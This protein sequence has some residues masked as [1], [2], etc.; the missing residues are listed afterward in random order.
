MLH[1]EGSLSFGQ[2]GRDL[3]RAMLRDERHNRVLPMLQDR[4]DPCSAP[5]VALVRHMPLL[6]FEREVKRARLDKYLLRRMHKDANSQAAQALVE[7]RQTAGVTLRDKWATLCPSMAPLVLGLV[8]QPTGGQCLVANWVSP[9]QRVVP[10]LVAE[11]ERAENKDVL[12]ALLSERAGKH[13]EQRHVEEQP[14]PEGPRRSARDKPSCLEAGVCLC[15]PGGNLVWRFHS[16]VKGSLKQFERRC[17]M[18]AAVNECRMVV[19][20]TKQAVDEEPE[21]P[22]GTP[23]PPA[24]YDAVFFIGLM[25]WNPHRPTLRECSYSKVNGLGCLELRCQDKYTTCWQLCSSLKPHL[26]GDGDWTTRC[27][28]VQQF[29]RPVLRLDPRHIEVMEVLGAFEARSRFP[30][31]ARARAARAANPWLRALDDVSEEGSSSTDDEAEADQQGEPAESEGE[32]SDKSGMSSSVSLEG[33]DP[34]ATPQLSDHDGDEPFWHQLDIAACMDGDGGPLLAEPPDERPS[35]IFEDGG[36]VDLM[37]VAEAPEVDPELAVEAPAVPDGAPELPAVPDGAPELPAIAG[38]GLAPQGVG[39]ADVSVDFGFGNIRFYFSRLELV[40]QCANPLHGIRCRLS[41][42]VQ[43]SGTAWR[44]GQGRPLGLMAAW[45]L[46]GQDDQLAIPTHAD[47]VKTR[48]WPK[49]SLEDRVAARAAIAAHPAGAA[50][51]AAERPRRPGEPEEP[52]TV[53]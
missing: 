16:F 4:V 37:V 24:L 36:V 23:E 41:R 13:K 21:G 11:L 39:A 26:E 50:L 15:G 46:A 45:L 14:L 33:S 17:N 31:T 20:L 12:D 8:P 35:D 53:P 44:H 30:Q 40:A 29:Q 6:D 9:C 27:Y 10:R 43:G 48:T 32:A 28:E 47:H 42:S 3:G 1:R 52:E 34:C 19:R 2:V 22:P 7:W 18:R 5:R 25:Y 51:I 49:P 38:G